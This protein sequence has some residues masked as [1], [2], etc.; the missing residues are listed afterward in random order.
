MLN[1]ESNTSIYNETVKEIIHVDESEFEKMY[2]MFTQETDYFKNN[3]HIFT[4]AVLIGKFI[5]KKRKKINKRHDFIRHS[6]IKDSDEEVILTALAIQEVNDVDVIIDKNE[7]YTICEEYARSGIQ[8]L[9]EWYVD[10]SIDFDIELT[11]LINE[12]FEE[13]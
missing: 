6:Y 5:V 9:Y 11:N 8:K 2:Q 12:F 4:L 10:S 7:I 1:Y 13:E 3:Q